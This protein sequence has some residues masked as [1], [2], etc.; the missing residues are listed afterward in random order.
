MIR[1]PPRSTRTYTLFPYTTLFRSAAGDWP[2]EAVTMMDSIAHSVERDPGYFGRL[3]YTETK[4]DPTTADALAEGAGSIVSV[5]GASAIT[6]FTSSGS[7]VCRVARERPMTPI[8]ALTPRQDT[9]RKLGLTW[10][11]HA[12]RTKDIGTFEDRK[13][14]RLNSS[15]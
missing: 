4:P 13:S 9:A 6:C 10:G 12:V 5:V 3:H 14:T 11:V 1:R 15:H 7:T 8:L 2:V